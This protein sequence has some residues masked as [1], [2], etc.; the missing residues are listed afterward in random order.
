MNLKPPTG[1]AVVIEQTK[2]GFGAYVPD[3]AGC[4]AVG[5]TVEEVESLIRE[6]IAMHIDGMLEDGL[7]VP[8]PTTRIEYVSPRVA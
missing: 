6:A 7:E 4:V 1:Y 5:D 3:L 2:D 8:R